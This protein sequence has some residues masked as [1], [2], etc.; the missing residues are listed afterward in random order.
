MEK[1]KLADRISTITNPPI[2]TGATTSKT[3]YKN[4]SFTVSASDIASGVKNLY[5]KKGKTK[6]K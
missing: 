4:S 5:I 6:F 2:I 3:N 1:I